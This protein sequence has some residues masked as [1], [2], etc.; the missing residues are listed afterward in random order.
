[1]KNNRAAFTLIELLV[2]VLIISILA[3]IALP[4]YFKAV[5]KS[6]AADALTTL[7]AVERAINTY[8]LT[9]GTPTNVFDNLDIT[10]S[11]TQ[12]A[13]N[14]IQGNNFTFDIRNINAGGREN[15]FEIVA[16]RNDATANTV[17]HYYIYRHY[18]GGF[19]CTAMSAAA[20]VVCEGITGKQ[21]DAPN[22]PSGYYYYGM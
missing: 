16:T 6:R 9:N 21:L 15:T 19:Q 17:R 10:I 22:H 7:K 1:M 8:I 4:Q 3:G 12:L 20:K 2:T 13:P 5:E 11:G 18:L 14:K